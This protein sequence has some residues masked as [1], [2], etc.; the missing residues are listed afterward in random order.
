MLRGRGGAESSSAA[1]GKI[2]AIL[3][4]Y[5]GGLPVR[6][7]DESAPLIRSW[8][9]TATRPDGSLRVACAVSRGVAS[10][11]GNASGAPG[12]EAGT[13]EAGTVGGGAA[14]RAIP[15][16]QLTYDQL[17]GAA[18][19]LTERGFEAIE[20]FE[21][22]RTVA[23]DVRRPAAKS[24]ASVKVDGKAGGKA[25]A[26]ITIADDASADVDARAASDAAADTDTVIAADT[27][28]VIAA[29][30]AADTET[31]PE[32]DTETEPTETGGKKRRRGLRRREAVSAA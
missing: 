18:A 26:E 22:W 16:L 19:A 2:V 21:G 11:A 9:L 24:A 30:T 28:T 10:G 25:E 23:L 6:E 12:I 15:D 17:V 1:A 7:T 20:V 5:V 14:T 32:T 8:T 29:E 31:E 4:T 13:V 27:D 3:E